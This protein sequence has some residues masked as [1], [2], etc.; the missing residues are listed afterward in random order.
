MSTNLTK[1]RPKIR[2]FFDDS[3]E[4]S[5]GQERSKLIVN[6]VLQLALN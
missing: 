3:G 6:H 4:V 5:S 2:T 1:W